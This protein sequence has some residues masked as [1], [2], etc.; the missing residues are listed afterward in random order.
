MALRV[1]VFS[2]AQ[3]PIVDYPLDYIHLDLANRLIELKQAIASLWDR[4]GRVIGITLQQQ[5]FG[6]IREEISFP[7]LSSGGRAGHWFTSQVSMLA[8][9]EALVITTKQLSL[10]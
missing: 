4:R 2:R 9:G 6:E 8:S 3:N 7:L 1:R 10:R 5:H